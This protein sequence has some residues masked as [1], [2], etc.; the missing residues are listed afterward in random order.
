MFIG[1]FEHTID[2]KGRLAVPFRFRVGLGTGGIVT[3]SIEKCLV[4]YTQ[5]EWEK[6]AEKLASLPMF[7]DKAR[8]VSRFIFSGAVEV[9]F[10]RQGRA[11]IPQY[12]RDYAGLRK[13]VIVAGLYNK[14]EVWN[15][16]AWTKQQRKA[17]VGTEEFNNQLRDLGI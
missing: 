6:V 10:D 17:G 13:N 3:R 14:I 15:E 8:S 16:E 12:L 2:P 9:E 4:I 5:A 1:E 7:D 11:L